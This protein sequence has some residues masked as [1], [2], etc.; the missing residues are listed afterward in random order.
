M[1]GPSIGVKAIK[2][3]AQYWGKGDIKTIDCTALL[4]TDKEGKF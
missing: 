3:E 4:M 2:D 1:A